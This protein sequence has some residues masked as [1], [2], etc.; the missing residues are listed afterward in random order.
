M[1]SHA[2]TRNVLVGVFALDTVPKYHEK[3]SRSR[4]YII[5][6]DISS[7]GGEHWICIYFP[8]YGMPEYFDSYGGSPMVYSN[9][10]ALMGLPFRKNNIRLQ[11]YLSTTCGQYCMTYIYMRHVCHYS[12][13]DVIKHLLSKRPNVDEYVN[14]FVER[15][16]QT[17]LDVQDANFLH[18]Q[19][20]RLT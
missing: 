20:S 11:N 9:L 5:N 14:L 18:K 8:L 15:M 3:L 10:I 16:F 13:N 12:M 17:D 19:L 4:A 7:G 6:T 2:G 1:R